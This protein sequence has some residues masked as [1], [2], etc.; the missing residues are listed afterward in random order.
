[1]ARPKNPVIEYRNYNLPHDFPII[2]LTGEVWRISDARSG[3]LHFHNCL[4]IG[5]CETDSGIIEF[6]DTS[7][8]FYADNITVIAS[9]VPHT[10]YSSPG[11]QSKWSY[12][13]IDTETIWGSYFPI[14]IL[15]D[16]ELILDLFHNYYTI[17]SKENHPEIY[18]LI[19]MIINEL[20]T[21]NNN[22]QLIVR[23]F[24]LAL[25]FKLLRIYKEEKLHTL[26]DY[27]FHENSFVISPALSLIRSH[28]MNDFSIED[29]ATLCHLS[30][31]HF[32]RVFTS[33]MGYNPLEFVNNTRIVNASILLRTTEMPILDIS[34][35]VG[36]RSVSSFNRHFLTILG[37]TPME[38]R[39]EMSY[40][41]NRSVFTYTGWIAPPKQI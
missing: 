36:F 30:T 11:T 38:Y 24:V 14:D 3:R 7:R 15:P 29:L 28:Y 16:R 34:E 25:L 6:M 1:M 5:L 18:A 12:V 37:M 2:L 31:A 27:E 26:Q 9:D 33:I 8:T 40:I 10:T 4:E 20:K 32:R 35:E 19:T 23:G 17:L 13:F 21:Q 41:R 39:K 22:Y